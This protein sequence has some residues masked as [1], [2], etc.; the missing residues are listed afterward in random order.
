VAV[1][2]PSSTELLRIA[3]ALGF[4]F[5]AGDVDF[6]RDLLSGALKTYETLDRLPD[7]LP[8]PRYPRL[9]GHIPAATENPFGA[10]ARKIDIAGAANG[11]LTGRTM[12]IKDCICVAGV[13][14]MNGSATLEGYT[15]E[16]DA[17]V[18]TRVL[19]AG[20]RVVAKSAN[21]DFCFSGGSHTNARGPVDNP[22]KPGHSAGGSS[23]GSA[24]LVGGGIVDMAL[25]TDQGGS[26]RQP[27]ACSG[28]VGMKPTFGLVPC[29]GNLGMEYSLDHIGPMTRTVADNALLLS[30]IAG[31]D[32]L[33]TRQAGV[34]L[35]DYGAD[36]NTGVAGLRIGLLA[37]GF[38]LPQSD[39]RVDATVRAAA[40]RLA[41]EGAA[42]ASVSVPMQR[43][44]GAI[45]LPRANEGIFATIFQGNG[46]GYGPKGVYLDSAMQRQA[47]WRSQADLLADT[48][49]VGMLAGAYM[50]GAYGGRYYA[51]SQ[52]LARLLVAA[53]DKALAK[54]DVL[55]TPTVPVT[56]PRH[57]P[58]EAGR[59]AVIAT[60]YGMT[61]NTA[62]FNVTGHPSLSIPSGWIDGL[63]V[64][65]MITGR[66]W[67]ERLLY[68]VAAALERRLTADG[69]TGAAAQER[70]IGA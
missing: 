68:R 33:D 59:S 29:T 27:A 14:L 70:S 24:A 52:N 69:V 5:D 36:L 9:P 3:T 55:V 50:H 12:A 6:F 51:R 10:Y 22:W 65:L 47:M 19:D 13:P 23:S 37:E 45:W 35:D 8:D 32:G 38:G 49:K 67:N 64:G 31:P 58:A 54:V 60:A 25:G 4:H 41:S 43:D 53:Y 56:A 48:V 26:V 34:S 15:P 21:E 57:P 11:P 42:V 63:P 1:K 16:I 61:I 44:A 62:P 46:Y 39:P 7:A 18:V 2:P 20:G 30:V 66:F 28:I 40:E 17:T